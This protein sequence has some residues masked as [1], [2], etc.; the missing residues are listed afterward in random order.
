MRLPETGRGRRAAAVLFL[1]A[2]AL[3]TGPGLPAAAK[4]L[5]TV[6]AALAKAFPDSTIEREIFYLT[7]EQ[8]AQ[9]ETLSG[10]DV[11]HRIA[12]PARAYRRGEL[13]GTAYFDTHR[14]RTLPE[15]LMVVVGPKGEVRELRVL[16][17][18]EP[19]D[20]LPGDPWYHQFVDRRLDRKLALGRDIHGV[21]GATLT[22]RATT[23][24]VRRVLA[25]HQVIWEDGTGGS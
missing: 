14:V 10:L 15:T 8:R 24:A 9:A 13:L 17:F 18:K 22:A 25:L 19:L 11:D 1:A 23:D 20:Y 7:D 16:S 5:L 6:E 3:S 2:L 4:V 21:T 12:R